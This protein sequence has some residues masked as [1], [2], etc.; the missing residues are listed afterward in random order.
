MAAKKSNGA[1]TLFRMED[2][3]VTA[4]KKGSLY[5]GYVGG[6]ALG[7]VVAANKTVVFI[8]LKSDI[9]ALFIFVYIIH[10]LIHYFIHITI[11]SNYFISSFTHRYVI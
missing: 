9:L 7:A 3:G 6:Y 1:K 8:E 2:K 5:H 10:C 11:T 4:D